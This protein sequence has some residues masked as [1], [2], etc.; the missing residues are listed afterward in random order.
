MASKSPWAISRLHQPIAQGLGPYSVRHIKVPQQQTP[1]RALLL[2]NMLSPLLWLEVHLGTRLCTT[3]Y[4]TLVEESTIVPFSVNSMSFTVS[5]DS[6]DR[7]LIRAFCQNWYKQT[8]C[9]VGHCALFNAV[10]RSQWVCYCTP[11]P[12]S[13]RQHGLCEPWSWSV[14]RK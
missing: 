6:A 13:S 3:S 8:Y 1:V 4:F 2:P 11:F 9:N 10:C 14:V 5:T 12:H 7:P